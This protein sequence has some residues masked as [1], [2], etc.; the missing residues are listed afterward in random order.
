MKNRSTFIAGL[1]LITGSVLTSCTSS[2][3]AVIEAEKNVTEANQEL[4]DANEAYLA[5]IL[6]Y[7][8]ETQ[9]KVEANNKSIAEFN[10]RIANEKKQ[11]K[12]DYQKQIAELNQKNTD[13]ELRMENYQADG[14]TNWEKFKYDFNRDMDAL[15]QSFLDFMSGDKK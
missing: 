6:M 11:A 5:D 4:E 12:E 7:R 14:L 3:D 8:A 9:R 1:A 15:T 2:A 13:M 10:V